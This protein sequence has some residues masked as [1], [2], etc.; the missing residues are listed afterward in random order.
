V[1]GSRRAG[2]EGDVF[3]AGAFVDS[4]RDEGGGHL[5]VL[6]CREIGADKVGKDVIYLVICA[7]WKRLVELFC[8][9]DRSMMEYVVVG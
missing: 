6:G 7:L 2:V 5:D 3:V 4:E 1:S 8:V 9:S